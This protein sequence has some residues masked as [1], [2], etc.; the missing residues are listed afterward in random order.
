[1]AIFSDRS[2]FVHGRE[3]PSE[4]K[5]LSNCNLFMHV[6]NDMI[7]IKDNKKQENIQSHIS[8]LKCLISNYWF[9]TLNIT[10]TYIQLKTVF[11]SLIINSSNDH[12]KFLVIELFEHFAR[13]PQSQDQNAKNMFYESYFKPLMLE[14]RK[15]DIPMLTH[16]YH[17]Y[18][19]YFHYISENFELKTHPINLLQLN[20]SAV[21]KVILDELY[22][23]VS[24]SS[25]IPQKYY[26]LIITLY[27]IIQHDEKILRIDLLDDTGSLTSKSVTTLRN[28]FDIFASNTD[29]SMCTDDFRRYIIACGAG[30]NSA[31]TS[32]IASVFDNKDNL[33]FKSFC[34]FY[35]A[36]VGGRPE[37][38]WNDFNAYSYNHNME[39][40][41]FKVRFKGYY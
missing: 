28:I 31:S 3:E 21:I 16:L 39:Y 23:T 41:E 15:S 37:H 6:T 36:A 8:F 1:M 2:Y 17:C 32:R 18:E 33:P 5:L 20:N 19:L 22:A 29:G 9:Q 40:Q 26:H 38:V 4:F 10:Y 30:P 24:A 35:K 27:N 13:T 12:D 34:R 14:C 7:F 25:K 11:D